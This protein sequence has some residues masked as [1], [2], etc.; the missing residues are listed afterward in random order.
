MS[1]FKKASICFLASAFCVSAFSACNSQTEARLSGDIIG[2]TA[3]SATKSSNVSANK[4]VGTQIKQ[5]ANKMIQ[6]PTINEKMFIE[7]VGQGDIATAQEMLNTGVDI[8]A[9]YGHGVYADTPLGLAIGKH[10]R[11][12]QQFLLM[13]HADVTGYT[14]VKG[15]HSYLV[16]AA[17]HYD[18]ELMEYLNNWGADINS[19]HN[20]NG[21]YG[22]ANALTMA[23]THSLYTTGGGFPYCKNENETIA[24]MSKMLDF[25]VSRGL[26]VNF[27]MKANNE[28]RGNALVI[29]SQ[30]S[31]NDFH[32]GFNARRALIK[33][34]LEVG[35]DPNCRDSKGKTALDYV[36]MDQVLWKAD[37]ESA[38]LIQQYMK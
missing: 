2:I 36:L 35:A 1:F 17:E 12:M 9:I 26:D 7:A 16:D 5:K 27:V 4:N 22:H 3:K 31:L 25:L 19:A 18:F 8:N 10:N 21:Y 34:L 37:I 15:F 38:K 33:K 28:S 20:F 23:Y 32:Y 14:D 24:N 13:N 11:E 6:N 29:V 30:I